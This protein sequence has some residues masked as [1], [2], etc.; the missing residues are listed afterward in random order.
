MRARRTCDTRRIE[1]GGPSVGGDASFSLGLHDVAWVDAQ[2]LFGVRQAW[3]FTPRNGPAH[4]EPRARA[5]RADACAALRRHGALR[6]ACPE[7]RRRAQGER[8]F[9]ASAGRRQLPGMLMGNKTLAV[10]E[11]PRPQ[12]SPACG[13]GGQELLPLPLAGEGGG[14][15]RRTTTGLVSPRTP[16]AH[17]DWNAL[18][19]MWLRHFVLPLAVLSTLRS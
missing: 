19:P 16:G 8:G 13:R 15:G 10:R 14:E 11:H 5:G 3:C 2:G 17:G 1:S 7:R 4:D 12:P 18:K 6:Q 9:S